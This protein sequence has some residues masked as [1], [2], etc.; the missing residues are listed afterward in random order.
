MRVFF[1]F[2]HYSLRLIADPVTGH[3]RTHRT[4]GHPRLRNLH[5]SVGLADVWTVL[6]RGLLLD[7]LKKAQRRDPAT[8]EGRTLTW[9]WLT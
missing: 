7:R 9:L 6:E 8:R 5:A 4:T 3:N 1:G 2:A